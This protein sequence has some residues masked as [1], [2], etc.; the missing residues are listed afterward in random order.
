MPI[1][2]RKL[3]YQTWILSMYVS[4]HT[5]YLLLI[6]ILISWNAYNTYQYQILAERQS[7]LENILTELL[8]LSFSHHES[9][10]IK[11]WFNKISHFLQ[12]LTSKDPYTVRM[13]ILFF[14]FTLNS[15]ELH[16]RNIKNFKPSVTMM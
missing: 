11:Q 15:E 2:K 8:P 7:K 10:T 9:T 16:S 4:I 13:K 12:R 14:L 5:L 1:D 6:F 3:N